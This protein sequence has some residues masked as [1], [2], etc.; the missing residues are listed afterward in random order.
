MKKYL[1][2]LLAIAMI[3]TL[4]GCNVTPDDTGSEIVAGETVTEDGYIVEGSGSSTNKDNSSSS[5]SS[6]SSSNNE[7]A[8]NRN[9]VFEET[10]KD[11]DTS[12]KV[13]DLKG[14]TIRI[15]TGLI[16]S[17]TNPNSAEGLKIME[18]K[19]NI[20]KK[21]NCK[22]VTV[23]YNVDKTIASIA[24]G[25]PDT[26]IWNLNNSA[27]FTRA[28]NAKM[29][30]PLE[31]LGVLDLGD[32]TKFSNY[33]G[34]F[35]MK[36]Q[37]Y[38]FNPQLYGIMLICSNTIMLANKNVLKSK[39]VNIQDIYNLQDQGKWTWE[40]FA[41]IAKKVSDPAS[42]KYAIQE[43]P[44]G[45][46]Y[47]ALMTSN[48]TDY[49]VMENGK[50]KFNAG[51]KEARETM[52]F[53]AR[54]M[55]DKS[56]SP[57]YAKDELVMMKDLLSG[58]ICFAS[59]IVAYHS[60]IW[61]YIEDQ[62]SNIAIL[63]IPKPNASAEYKSYLEGAC[64]VGIPVY[65]GKDAELRARETATIIGE[66]FAPV[67]SQADYQKQMQAQCKQAGGD[68]HGVKTLMELYGKTVFSY[69]ALGGKVTTDN[70]KGWIDQVLNI[71][72]NPTSYQSVIDT[73]SSNYNSILSKVFG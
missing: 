58:N 4:G 18:L 21:Y 40:E 57:D 59:G 63:Y 35:R 37:H 32:R 55:T 19:K 6:S 25:T 34:A 64:P 28:Y 60:P 30:Q 20:E 36:G 42:G 16:Q 12:G 69:N 8:P 10:N 53:Y 45:R 56:L 14:R 41:K 13:M 22:I 2:I 52:D 24:S 65:A 31:P 5:T 15:T 3:A 72:K 33:T 46:L 43:L 49:I 62:S 51:S 9:E 38:A 73:Y 70:G 50:L 68:E 26:D 44:T 67:S 39:G 71:A 7:K 23:P 48:S 61:P 29:L 11:Y 66:L 27:N 54:L 17:D 47:N 1:A